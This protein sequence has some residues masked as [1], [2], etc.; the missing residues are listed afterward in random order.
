VLQ[1]PPDPIKSP[2]HNHCEPCAAGVEKQPIETRP[3]ILRAA[4]L[5]GIF[6]VNDPAPR[7]AVAT[8]L[9]ELVLA[10]LGTVGGADT[11]VDGGLHGNTALTSAVILSPSQSMP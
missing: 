5:V 2:A 11:G 7:L 10:G 9:E 1:V 3:T 6:S 4:H 8:E